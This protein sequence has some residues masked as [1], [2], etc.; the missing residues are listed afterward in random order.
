VLRK[1]KRTAEKENERERQGGPSKGGK[2][3]SGEATANLGKGGKEFEDGGKGG[4]GRTGDVDL[5]I[6]LRKAKGASW[7]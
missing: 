4:T 5:G 6:V 7:K 1:K 2:T 3:K